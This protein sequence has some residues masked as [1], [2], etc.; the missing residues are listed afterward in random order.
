MSEHPLQATIVDA[1]PLGN[2]LL[3]SVRGLGRRP[4]LPAEALVIQTGERTRLLD[5]PHSPTMWLHGEVTLLAE[6][7][8]EVDWRHWKGKTL[9]IYEVGEL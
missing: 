5:Q 3:L 7:L 9:A 2:R 8:G 6:P 1:L 4:A